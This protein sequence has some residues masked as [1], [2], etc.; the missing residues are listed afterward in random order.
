A[1]V[2]AAGLAHPRRAPRPG[3][4]HRGRHV[5]ERLLHLVEVPRVLHLPRQV[6]VLAG[7]EVVDVVRH[8]VDGAAPR[9]PQHL[10]EPRAVV[11]PARREHLR[12]LAAAAVHTL[13]RLPQHRHV[14]AVLRRRHPRRDAAAGQLVAEL[15]RL[16]A[17][18]LAGGV[19]HQVERVPGVPVAGVQRVLAAG[20]LP[21]ALERVQPERHL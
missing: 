13:H 5:A 20:G 6:P 8:A 10:R 19:P 3:A 16:D 17:V 12:H 1:V 15:P 9:H 11:E 7:A 4:P 14:A 18:A 21:P 2:R